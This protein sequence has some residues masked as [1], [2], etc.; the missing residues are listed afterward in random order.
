MVHFDPGVFQQMPVHKIGRGYKRT[1]DVS[2]E[3]VDVPKIILPQN[4]HFIAK[5]KAGSTGNLLVIISA[6]L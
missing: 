5:L 3:E 2:L 4:P 1:N 6:L